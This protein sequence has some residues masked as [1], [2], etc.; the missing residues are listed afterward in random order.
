MRK[1][2]DFLIRKRHWFLFILLEVVSCIFLYYNQAYH[3][4][5]ILGSSNTLVG[6]ISSISGAVRSYIGL[7]GE[8]E[9]SLNGTVSWSFR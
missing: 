1:L 9:H 2:L 8:N 6:H 3:R 4:N 5:L 7:K